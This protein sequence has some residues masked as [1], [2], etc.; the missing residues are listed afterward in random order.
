MTALVT[1]LR[2]LVAALFSTT[3]GSEGIVITFFEWLTSEAVLP[4]F[5]IGIC[6][7]LVLLAVK[8]VRGTIWASA[9]EDE[10]DRRAIRFSRPIIR[11]F[12]R[13]A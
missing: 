1:N 8:I 2:A 6:V 13:A 7:S 3:A 11:F 5:A 12:N 4:Y 10:Y 9:A